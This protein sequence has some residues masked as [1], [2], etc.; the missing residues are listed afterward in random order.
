MLFFS[1]W[2]IPFQNSPQNSAT[3]IFPSF[4]LSH[5]R[6]TCGWYFRQDRR[7]YPQISKSSFVVY[8]LIRSLIKSLSTA[9]LNVTHLNLLISEA[10]TLL[11]CFTGTAACYT[12]DWGIYGTT[13][14]DMLHH[15]GSVRWCRWLRHCAIRRRVAVSI[16]YWHTR[17]PSGRT[18]VLESTQ[19][20]IEMST[21]NISRCVEAVGA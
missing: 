3:K 14:R 11:H 9:T 7:F 1:I 12:T 15:K 16:L 8:C 10:R 2:R 18:K 20:L 21:R 5:S 17:N 6:Q 19:T 4:F 13:S